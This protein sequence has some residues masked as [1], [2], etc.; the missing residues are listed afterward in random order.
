MK[1]GNTCQ[2]C[3]SFTKLVNNVCEPCPMDEI[4]SAD[5]TC[6]KCPTGYKTIDQ[7]S[8]ILDIVPCLPRQKRISNKKCEDCPL[9][10]YLANDKMEC[11]GCP[12][13]QVASPL[14]VC[15]NC[16]AGFKTSDQRTCDPIIKQCG[17]R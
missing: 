6:T 15:T 11:L 5:G 13:N 12:R 16:P 4:A 10:T 8:C 3:P 14:G 2:T 9:Y 1:I 17:P 7:K